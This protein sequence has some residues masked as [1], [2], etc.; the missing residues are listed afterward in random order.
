MAYNNFTLELTQDKFELSLSRERFCQSL[1]IV[2]VQPE[3]LTLR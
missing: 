1:P 3:F 2:D